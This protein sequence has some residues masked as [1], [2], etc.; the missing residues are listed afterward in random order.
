MFEDDGILHT[1][2]NSQTHKMKNFKQHMLKAFNFWDMHESTKLQSIWVYQ[3]EHWCALIVTFGQHSDY[4][5]PSCDCCRLVEW[6]F[7]HK[8]C[9]IHRIVCKESSLLACSCHI[10]LENFIHKEQSSG[11]RCVLHSM[12][13]HELLQELLVEVPSC[14]TW[15][16]LSSFFPT[17]SRFLQKAMLRYLLQHLMET[18]MQKTK[19]LSTYVV[20]EFLF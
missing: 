11:S 3:P 7:M 19:C 9:L 6:N 4:P 2:M 5:V 16:E 13:D 18:F 17:I 10:H 14:I 12:H 1:H 20:Y 8:I 15:C